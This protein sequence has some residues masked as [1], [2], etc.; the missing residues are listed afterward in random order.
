[1]LDMWS[2]TPGFAVTI[3][4]NLGDQSKIHKT[5]AHSATGREKRGSREVGT[6]L[7]PA[8]ARAV[9]I[10]DALADHD[11]VPISLSDLARMLRLPKSSTGNLC[12]TLVE[13]GLVARH[14]GGFVLGRKL[15]ELGGRYL[16]TVDE[17]KEFYHLCRSSPLLSRETV[18]ASVLD[19]LDVLY[20]ARYDG[21]RPLRLTA[22]IG[23]RFP[24]TCTA[25]GKALLASLDPAVLRDRLSRVATLPVLTSRSIASVPE[26]LVELDKVR[27][28]GWS[29]DDEETTSGVT[30]LAIA[31]G[32]EGV[33]ARFAVSVTILTSRLGQD[34]R[35][36]DLLQEL[37]A[38]RKG[39]PSPPLAH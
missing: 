9:A 32:Q 12:A 31:V 33:S 39:L 25:T 16:S 21:N 11:G 4:G 38:L 14:D 1:M 20:L 30:C 23:D 29:E 5:K 7:V 19:G 34:V 6:V 3:R 15:A 27:E 26:L 13:T 18:R 35:R 10:L 24:A 2:S 8:I 17:V 36:E 22:N 37:F 28:R